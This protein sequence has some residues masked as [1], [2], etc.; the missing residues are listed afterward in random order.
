MVHR[1]LLPPLLPLLPLLLALL[2]PLQLAASAEHPAA[3]A[4]DPLAAVLRLVDRE[5]DALGEAT[6]AAE[7]AGVDCYLERASLEVGRYFRAVASQDNTSASMTQLL[8]HYEFFYADAP[9]GFAAERARGLPVREANDTLALL[10]NAMSALSAAR[11]QQPSARPSLPSRSMLGATVCDGYLCN[12]KGQPVIPVGLNVWGFPRSPSPFD[13][14]A[15]GISL[16]TTGFGVDQLLENLTLPDEYVTRLR[17]ELDAAAAKNISIHTLGFGSMPAWAEQKWPGIISGNFTQHGVNFDISSPGVPILLRAGIKDLFARIG[18]HPALGG[19]I[20]GN[21]V[22]FMQSSTPATI[23]SYRFFLRT[24]YKNNIGLL[25][26]AWDL[27]A[28]GLSSFDGVLA[29]P[30]KPTDPVTSGGQAAQWMDWN[31]FNNARVTELYTVMAD[32]IHAAASATDP[33]QF[34][35]GCNTT[36]LKLQD[37]NEWGTGGGLRFKG[38]DREALVDVLD[39][40][41]CDSGIASNTG[42]DSRGRINAKS[43]VAN[44]PPNLANPKGGGQVRKTALFAPFIYK[45]HLFT[46][47]GSGQT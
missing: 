21:E 3:S 11:R 34:H 25:N 31:L 12:T 28:A 8:G 33:A 5:L 14:Q 2:L 18:C 13:E 24:R 39:W 36:T 42:L 10:R 15:A 35:E 40:N 41:G 19:F 37:G 23:A 9:E 4:D 22:T 44:P 26:Q 46:K 20:L 7:A 6:H 16:V 27:G 45:S 1:R 47:T 17:A 29:Q 43:R 32:A 38:I 30:A